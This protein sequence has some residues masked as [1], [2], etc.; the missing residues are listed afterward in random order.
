MAIQFTDP[1]P[2]FGDPVPVRH[3]SPAGYPVPES[4]GGEQPRVSAAPASGCIAPDATC[5]IS[6]AYARY[7]GTWSAFHA[8]GQSIEREVM[9][10]SVPVDRDGA[11]P[12]R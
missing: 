1:S 11:I 8:G 2:S 7:T 4:A 5:Q 12:A 6:N 10:L 9:L 3:G